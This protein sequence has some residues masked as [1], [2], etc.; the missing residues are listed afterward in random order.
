MPSFPATRMRRLRATPALRASVRETV[1]RPAN[2]GLPMF[3]H[4]LD[5][6]APIPSMPGHARL[7]VDDA[8]ALA[9]RAQEAG[10]AGV[11]LFGIPQAKDAEG[12]ES[13]NPDGVLQRAVRA[14][15][16]E[17]PELPVY[18]DVCMCGYLDHGHCGPVD[19]EG[20]IVNDVALESIVRIA[21]S[22]ADAGATVLAPSDM[23]DGR[24]GAIRAALEEHG[25]HDVAI[26]THA[27][28]FASAFY[29]PFR[30]AAGSAPAFGD[31]RAYQMDPANGDEAVREALLDMDEGADMLMVKPALSYLDVIHRVRERTGMP[32][33]CYHVSG[34]YAMAKAAAANGWVDERGVILEA[35]TGMCRAGATVIF[36]YAALDAAG[37][38]AEGA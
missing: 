35:L 21:L 32:V 10:L 11:M 17:V 29:G 30:D 13:W 19:D 14:I 31:R 6:P 34:E 22:H 33:A 7:P 37:W 36:T 23:M 8:V 27:A 15:R 5:E 16:A 38:L 24:V 3:V 9:R 20:R 1:L 28:K 4:E 25:H 18:T 2:L 12:A 26:M